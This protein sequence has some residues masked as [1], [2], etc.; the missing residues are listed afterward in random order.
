MWAA[1]VAA[2]PRQVP[3]DYGDNRVWPVTEV[4]FRV[5]PRQRQCARRAADARTH[6]EAFR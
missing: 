5:G 1:R 6:A 4:E 2:P 3:R